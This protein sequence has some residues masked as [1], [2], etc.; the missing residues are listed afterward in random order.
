MADPGFPREGGR[1]AWADRTIGGLWWL[2]A[3]VGVGLL[4]LAYLIAFFDRSGHTAAAV[5]AMVGFIGLEAGLT[6]S[7]LLGVQWPFGARVALMV[8]AAL[9]AVRA[10]GFGG[11][12][13]LV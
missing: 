7:A 2:V 6:L 11:I 13:S 10:V 5:F 8:A 1:M 9:L 12:S 3:A 4:L